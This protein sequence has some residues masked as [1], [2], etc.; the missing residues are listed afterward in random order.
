VT[1][2]GLGIAAV[3]LEHFKTAVA[4]YVGDLDQVRPALHRAGHETSAQAVAAEGRRIEAETASALLDDRSDVARI[5]S[6]SVLSHQCKASEEQ[7][8]LSVVA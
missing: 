8:P 5:P 6:G 2:E 7:R 4:G 1:D 3:S